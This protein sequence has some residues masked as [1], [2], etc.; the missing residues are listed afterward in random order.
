MT[1]ELM[2]SI[3]VCICEGSGGEGC[4]IFSPVGVLLQ[5]TYRL[6]YVLLAI[7]TGCS[8]GAPARQQQRV[9]RDVG[10]ASEVFT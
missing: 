7:A 2:T 4:L 8:I 10:T 6:K 1:Y 5:L 3:L 9:V